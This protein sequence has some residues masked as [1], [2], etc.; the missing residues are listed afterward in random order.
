MQVFAGE[1]MPPGTSRGSE[2]LHA[3][4]VQVPVGSP[5]K[6]HV[7]PPAELSYWRVERATETCTSHL[8]RTPVWCCGGLQGVGDFCCLPRAKAG[9]ALMARGSLW[10]RGDPQMLLQ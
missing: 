1:V 2:G 7:A 8:A 3:G 10:Q 5:G 4:G 9:G 6:L